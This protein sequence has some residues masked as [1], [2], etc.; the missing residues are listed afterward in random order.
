MTFFKSEKIYSDSKAVLT[1]F[2]VDFFGNDILEARNNYKQYNEEIYR[3]YY[4]KAIMFSCIDID[5]D[6][7]SDIVYVNSNGKICFSI[8]YLK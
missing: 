1:N 7:L 8:C 4:D 5:G 2:D 3:K 6:F